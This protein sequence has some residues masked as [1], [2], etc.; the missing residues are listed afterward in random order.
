MRLQLTE[1]VFLRVLDYY[2]GILFLTTNRAGVLDEAFKSRIHFKIYY[3]DLDWS[4]TRDIW[5]LNIDRVSKIEDELAR[6]EKRAPMMINSLELLAFAKWS[7][8]EA[9]TNKEVTRWNGRQIR[10]SF[11]VARSLAYYE[12]GKKI[13]EMEERYIRS[14]TQP[15]AAD[16]ELIGPPALVVRH[17]QMMQDLTASFDNYRQAIHGSTDANMQLDM[18]ARDDGYTDA[19]KKAQEAEYSREVQMRARQQELA[20]GMGQQSPGLM[21][22]PIMTP[23]SGYPQ[24][25][26]SRPTMIQNLGSNVGDLVYRAENPSPTQL[27][28]T[29]ASPTIVQQHRGSIGARNRSASH[30]TS[31]LSAGLAQPGSGYDPVQMELLL[32]QQQISRFTTTSPRNILGRD[33][34]PGPTTSPSDLSS[35]YLNSFAR[36]QQQQQQQQSSQYTT[37]NNSLPMGGGGL[38]SVPRGPSPGIGDNGLPLTSYQHQQQPGYLTQPQAGSFQPNLRETS[39]EAEPVASPLFASGSSGGFGT[40]FVGHGRSSL[41]RQGQPQGLN[42]QADEDLGLDDPYN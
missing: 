31:P 12:H 28:N 8:D 37:R 26:H 21:T 3:A 42:D 2:N 11:Q 13:Q 32:Q 34:V 35:S 1:P 29:N 20:L 30:V 33:T 14:G 15:T 19:V 7:F 27:D 24:R 10:N 18:G 36:Q 22:D 41:S 9:A 4:Q 5:Q 39:D 17:F 16:R 40:Q 6:I 23:T 38:A 25:N